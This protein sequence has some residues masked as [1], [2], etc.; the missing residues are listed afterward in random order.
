MRDDYV[1]LMIGFTEKYVIL[2][3]IL[4]RMDFYRLVLAFYIT[5]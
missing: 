2:Y 4:E 1:S 5:E 3:Y